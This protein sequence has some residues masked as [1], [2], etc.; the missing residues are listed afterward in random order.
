MHRPSHHE[1]TGKLRQ[2]QRTAAGKGIAFVEP[3]PIYADLLDLNYTVVNFVRQLPKILAEIKPRHYQG[4]RPPEKSYER[5]ILDCEL[6]AFRWLSKAFGCK[7]YLKFAFKGGSLW[8]VSIHE[9][10][11]E[12]GKKS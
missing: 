3:D 1:L 12:R 6:F 2:A 4:R 9:H 8:I 5:K 10:R 7:M 11:E